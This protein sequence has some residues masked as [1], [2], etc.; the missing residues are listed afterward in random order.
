MNNDDSVNELPQTSSASSLEIKTANHGLI[1][2]WLTLIHPLILF[3]IGATYYKDTLSLLLLIRSLSQVN[4]ASSGIRIVL[5]A[6][7]ISVATH[8]LQTLPEPIN[9]SQWLHGGMLVDFVGEKK[10]TRS[11]LIFSDV[12]IFALQWLYLILLHKK[13][14]DTEATE[15]R[16]TPAQTIEAE[17]AGIHEGQPED[18]GRA[19]DG[20]GI[21]MQNLLRPE[22]REQ[23][24]RTEQVQVQETIINIRKADILDVFRRSTSVA[25]SPESGDAFRRFVSRLNAVRARRAQLAAANATEAGTAPPAAPPM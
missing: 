23:E 2:S 11:G 7:L 1:D 21:E 22:E 12:F 6:T 25:T 20:E 4:I 14:S 16:Q 15:V 17:E 18:G 10:S 8:S 24:N 5:T 13:S 19:D 9:N 3:C